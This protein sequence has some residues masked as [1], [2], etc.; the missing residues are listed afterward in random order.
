MLK[1]YGLF[2][3]IISLSVQAG[4]EIKVIDGGSYDVTVSDHEP[5]RL[6]VRGDRIERIISARGSLDQWTDKDAGEVYLTPRPGV[7]DLEIYVKSVNSGTFTLH[8]HAQTVEGSSLL[9]FA[10]GRALTPLASKHDKEVTHVQ[11]IKSFIIRMATD[12]QSEPLKHPTVI[13]LWKEVHVVLKRHYMD[14]NAVGDVYELTNVSSA[15]LVMMES[16]FQTLGRHILA[17]SL[18]ARELAPGQST[19]IFIVQEVSDES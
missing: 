7:K 2:L 14:T 1:I 18:D 13:P 6:S 10:Q 3:L 15:R 16:E 4:Q 17:V 12:T 11:A 9:L 5:T 8:V 19:K